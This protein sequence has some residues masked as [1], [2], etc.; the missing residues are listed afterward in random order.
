MGLPER[1]RIAAYVGIAAALSWS[2]PIAPLR[3]QPLPIVPPELR[4]TFTAERSGEH[5]RGTIRTVFWNFGQIGDWPPDPLNVDLSVFHSFEAPVFSGMNNVDGITPFLLARITTAGGETAHIMEAGYRERLGV[6]PITGR[7]MRWEPRPGYFQPDSL[8][9]PTRSP[10]TSDD[11]ATWPASWPDKLDDPVDPGWP[12][13]WNGFYGKGAV[14]QQETYM[15]LDDQAY[16]A[17]DFQP[18]ARDATRRGLAL[19]IDVRSL[20]WTEPRARDAIFWNYD[21]TN[22]GTT[23]YDSLFF[24]MYLHSGIGGS[25]ISCD[26]LYEGEDDNAYFDRS[27]ARE[28]AYAWDRYGH[29]VALSGPCATT[30]L[31]G[32]AFLRTPG[33]AQDGTDN[34]RDGIVDEQQDGGPGMLILGSELILAYATAHY[35]TSLFRAYHGPLEDRPALVAGAWWTGDEDMDWRASEDDVG[36]DGRPGTG[37]TGECDGVPTAGEPDFDPRDVDE[38]D[39]LGLTGFKMNRIRAGAGNPDPHVDNIVFFDNE[40]HWPRRLWQHFTAADAAARYDSALAAHYQFAFLTASGSFSLGVGRTQRFT[41][42]L[43]YAPTLDSLRRVLTTAGLVH[44]GLYVPPAPVYSAPPGTETASRDVP[45]HAPNPTRGATR[46]EFVAGAAGA[47]RLEVMDLQGRVVADRDLGRV[48]P[49]RREVVFDSAG[50]RPGLYLYRIRLAEASGGA[51]RTTPAAKL[52][53]TR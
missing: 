15:V 33:Q 34:D 36:A 17:W 20:Q 2:T 18:D 42:A 53:V 46:I 4:S 47:A 5:C 21:I 13:S 7:L 27:E 44:R 26:G 51:Q 39:Q 35:D 19:R 41:V 25:G 12:G 14:A 22:E 49:G 10:A 11:P 48:S 40:N 24:G 1:G 32:C 37:D 43:L 38:I 31:I 50:L 8:V 3:A 52:V 9:N 29:G 28:L 16:D 30:G 6:S 45:T 23:A